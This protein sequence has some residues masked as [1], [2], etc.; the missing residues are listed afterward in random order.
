VCLSEL[1]HISP[2][3]AHTK[4]LSDE[5]R[6]ELLKV[7]H[8]LGASMKAG[9]VDIPVIEGFGIRMGVSAHV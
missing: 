6:G 1:T 3:T 8:R 7:E 2:L 4:K 5:I 9:A